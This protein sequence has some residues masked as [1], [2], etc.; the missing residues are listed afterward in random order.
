MAEVQAGREEDD[1]GLDPETQAP[2]LGVLKREFAGKAEVAEDD[3]KK[4]LGATVELVDH[5]QQEI[6]L[7]GFW[8]NAVAQGVL[9]NWIVQLLDDQNLFDFDK[10]PEVADRIVELAKV[11]QHKLTP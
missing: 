10:L 4:L 3:L 9:K 8:K 1:T 11:N 5:V 2:F 6:R 7:V